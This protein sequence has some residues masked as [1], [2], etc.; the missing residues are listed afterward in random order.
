MYES[1]LSND[2][3]TLKVFAL[4]K[5]PT[6]SNAVYPGYIIDLLHSLHS[7]CSH[8]QPAYSRQVVHIYACVYRSPSLYTPWLPNNIARHS[9]PMHCITLL[10]LFFSW[11][12]ANV[13]CW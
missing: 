11:I 5:L 2:R 10:G 6:V 12:A 13:G 9:C 7:M 8:D 3:E 4:L 1:I